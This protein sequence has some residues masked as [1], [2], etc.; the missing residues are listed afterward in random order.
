[1]V[2]AFPSFSW[3]FMKTQ[4]Y[5]EFSLILQVDLWNLSQSITLFSPNLKHKNKRVFKWEIRNILSIV[6]S[7]PYKDFMNEN[8]YI[9]D[10][11]I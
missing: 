7:S 11:L 9:K 1:M 8:I 6:L 5:L 4:S 2:V 10:I 3:F